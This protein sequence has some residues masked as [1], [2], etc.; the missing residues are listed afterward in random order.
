MATLGLLKNVFFILYHLMSRELNLC[1]CYTNENWVWTCR[2]L[3]TVLQEVQK[4]KIEVRKVGCNSCL[5]EP[6]RATYLQG[7][8]EL[9][10]K[11]YKNIHSSH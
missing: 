3:I 7:W 6:A 1:R 10:V 2:K 11:S 9:L 8:V 4:F 5:P